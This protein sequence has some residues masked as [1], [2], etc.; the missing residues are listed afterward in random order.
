LERKF[1][2]K[3]IDTFKPKMTAAGQAPPNSE[4]NA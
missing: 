4:S 2:T 1:A 3:V